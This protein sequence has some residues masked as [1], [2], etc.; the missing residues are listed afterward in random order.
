MARP[1]PKAQSRACASRL[2]LR[3]T[4]S[5]WL[6][7]EPE[8][9]EEALRATADG[10]QVLVERQTLADSVAPVEVT[11]PSGAASTLTL[12]KAEEGLWKGAFAAA[13]EGL[14]RLK[15]GDQTALVSA[16][17]ADSK[18][19]QD[20]ISDT[21]RLR[22]I[23]EATGGSVRRIATNATGDIHLPAVVSVTRSSAAS[24]ADFIGLRSSDS[25]VVTGLSIWPLFLGF[26]GL[27]L[28]G[29]LLAAAWFFE[30]RGMG[31]KAGA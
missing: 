23:A 7:K 12:A 26:A 28:I 25:Y 20:V 6:M 3:E 13:E 29:P 30:A 11:A 22:P 16:G 17:A 24:G 19:F 1:A 10:H 8:L 21:E 9:D 27:A 2:L 31:R 15:Q 18:E 14:Y 5:H 4:M